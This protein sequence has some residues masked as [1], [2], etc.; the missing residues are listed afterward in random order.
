MFPSAGADSPLASPHTSAKVSSGAVLNPLE[1][2]A[3]PT[4]QAAR[5]LLGQQDTRQGHGRRRGVLQVTRN[6]LKSPLL[7]FLVCC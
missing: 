5:T 3:I 6:E 4:A 7:A 2:F 1:V